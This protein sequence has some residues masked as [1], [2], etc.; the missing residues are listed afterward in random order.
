MSTSSGDSPFTDPERT[1]EPEIAEIRAMSL[2]DMLPYLIKRLIVMADHRLEEI[3]RSRTIDRRL[4]K[5][6]HQVGLLVAE[7]GRIVTR[8]GQ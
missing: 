5:L 1:T 3:E 4:E 6:E 7:V 8:G 2:E